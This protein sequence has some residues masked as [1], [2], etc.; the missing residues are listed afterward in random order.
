MN[1]KSKKLQF[2]ENE[3]R[4][5]PLKQYH[6]VMKNLGDMNYLILLLFFKGVKL[7]VISLLKMKLDFTM[8]GSQLVA[9][10]RTVGITIQLRTN[11]L[12]HSPLSKLL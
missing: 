1:L 6:H 8:R 5:I 7:D 4:E 11:I 2:I 12:K 3:E 10:H 9:V